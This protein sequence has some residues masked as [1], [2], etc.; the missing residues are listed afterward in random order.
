MPWNCCLKVLVKKSRLANKVIAAE[1]VKALWY[2]PLAIIQ[3][4]AFISKSGALDKYLDIYK[5]NRAQLLREKPSQSHDD[6]ASTVYTTWQISF[7]QLSEPAK[8]LL[9]LW[10]FLHHEGIPEE[11][12]SYASTYKS[13]PHGPTAEELKKPLE[14]L[15]HFMGPNF[16]WDSFH[17]MEVTNEIRAY[18]LVTFDPSKKSFS[19]HPL[20]HSWT[21]T[22]LMDTKSYHHSMVAI[23]G[24]AIA[25][26]PWQD[27]QLAS[28]KL[29]PHVDFL[30][31]G[32]GNVK[33]DFRYEYGGLYWLVGR[34]KDAEQL[35][36]A[37]LEDRRD[38][39]GDDHPDTLYA[40]GGLASIYYKLGEL[41][42]AEELDTA[43]LESGV[44]SWERTI[45]TPCWLWVSWH[46]HITSWV[47]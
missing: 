27:M 38:I 4:G 18:S 7:D 9:Q 36:L 16:L 12:F 14:F 23:V 5:E 39:L 33:P 2:L 26:I 32:N 42:E 44:R 3:A 35:E 10:S 15:S 25:E 34:L 45:Q 40:M 46:R 8:T 22:T 19:V 29:L 24:M 1:I 17:F 43:V 30:I 11:I 31:R 20:V 37:V 13:R 21:R 28:I 41:K 47:S 6:Y